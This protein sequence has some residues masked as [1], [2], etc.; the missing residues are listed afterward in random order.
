[1]KKMKGL[2][3]V[4]IVAITMVSCSTVPAGN[5]G[6]KFY[7]LGSDK[8]VDYQVLTPG[9]YWIGVNEKL[10]L[11]PTQHQ[12]MVW[13]ADQREGSPSD[14]HFDF[15]S[16]EGLQLK[17]NFAIEYHIK[18]PNVPSVFETYKQG[19]DEV[20]Q[21]ILRNVMRDAINESASYFTA[22]E[23]FG[24]KKMQ[25][26]DS[27]KVNAKQLAEVKKF[28]IDNVY[29]LGNIIPPASVVTAL[30]NKIKAKEIAQQTENELRQTEAEAKKVIAKADGEA[31]AILRKAEAQAKANRMIQQ[32]ITNALIDYEKVKRW[33]GKLPQVTGGGGV[34]LNLK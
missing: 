19:A 3:L 1:M 4:A 5:V 32:S 20:S 29:L 24:Q 27:V 16:K 26:M 9:R 2:L 22:A 33:D 8:G 25:F 15:Q 6:I 21:I 12:T 7:L 34:L 14:E 18:A 28:T 23:I 17:G 13:T 11:F 30:N 10:F 31:Q